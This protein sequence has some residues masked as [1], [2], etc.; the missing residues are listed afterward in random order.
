MKSRKLTYGVGFNDSNYQINQYI[1]VNGKYKIVWRCPFYMAW[2][3]MLRRC[4]S[5][6]YQKTHPTYKGCQVCEEWLTFSNFKAWMEMQSWKNKE[7]DKDL[8]SQNNKIYSPEY[9]IFVDARVNTFTTDSAK[10]RGEYLIGVC[11]DKNANK[12]KSTCRNP[13][14][15]KQEHLGLFDNELDA[16]L[17]WKNK[18]HEHA[19]KLA[20]TCDDKKLAQALRQRYSP[21]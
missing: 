3:N 17:M 2:T 19:L 15:N 1:K 13:F 16:H 9:C 12:F 5:E 4:Y 6:T 10:I 7:L 11:W 8:L 14:T 20:N 21:N 18:K